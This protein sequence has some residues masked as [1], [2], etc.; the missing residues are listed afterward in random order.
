MVRE[1]LFELG[2]LPISRN[3]SGELLGSSERKWGVGLHHLPQREPKG[4]GQYHLH[5]VSSAMKKASLSEIFQEGL[6]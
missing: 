6:F 2:R 5:A 4:E 3:G 1:H